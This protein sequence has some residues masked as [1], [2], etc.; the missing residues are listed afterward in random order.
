MIKLRTSPYVPGRPKGYWFKWKRD[1]NVV[2]AVLMYAQRGHGK[3]SLVLFRLHVRRVEGQ[4][5]R[6]DRQGLFR[7]YR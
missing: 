2:D 6:A 3:R 7:L 4:R 5:D 1:P